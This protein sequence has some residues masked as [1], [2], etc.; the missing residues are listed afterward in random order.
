MDLRIAHASRH[1]ALGDQR[2]EGK[3]SSC[4]GKQEINQNLLCSAHN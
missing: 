4:D 1:M 2:A 3:I